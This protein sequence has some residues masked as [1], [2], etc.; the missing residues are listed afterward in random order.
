MT[1]YCQ[2]CGEP[3]EPDEEEDG[4]CTSCKN[5]KLEEKEENSFDPNDVSYQ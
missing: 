5:S 4:I 2:I 3:L 1:D